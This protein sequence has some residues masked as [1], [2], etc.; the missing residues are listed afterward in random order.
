MLCAFESSDAFWLLSAELGSGV[1]TG[2]GSRNQ[3]YWKI[4]KTCVLLVR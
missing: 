4:T 1:G 2:H 3:G